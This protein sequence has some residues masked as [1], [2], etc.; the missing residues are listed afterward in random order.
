MVTFFPARLGEQHVA[1]SQ[2]AGISGAHV[3]TF[4]PFIPRE[5]VLLLA[6]SILGHLESRAP[7]QC[8]GS[9]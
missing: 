1:R 4:F 6:S 8:F 3:L 9:C 7:G 5:L 2:D